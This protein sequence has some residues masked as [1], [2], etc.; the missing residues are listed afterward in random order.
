MTDAPH[1]RVAI[2]GAG[3]AGLYAAAHLIEQ[4][5]L[6]IEVDLLDALPTPWGL[7]RSA[8]APDHPEKKLI[9]D[10]YF[11][12]ILSHPQV[13]FFGNIRVGRDIGAEALSG[14]Y[15][16][17]IYAT[18]ADGDMKLGIDGETLRGVWS[19]REFVA[20]YN[21]HPDFASLPVDL[22]SDRAVIFGN[23]NVALDAAR[24]LTRDP[25]HLARTEIADH[26]LA[27]LRRSRVKEVVIVGRRG[28]F[29]SAYNCPE[30][31]E[32]AHIPEVDIVARGIDPSDLRHDEDLSDVARRKAR[33][34]CELAS[35]PSR[36]GNR[37]LI[38]QFHRAPLAFEGEDRVESVLLRD[39]RDVDGPPSRLTSGFVLRA[40]G[41]RGTPFPDL[42]FDETLGLIANRDGRVWNAKGPVT[43]VY[44]TGWIKRGCRGVIGTN[45]KCARQSV[46]HL[47]DD[48]TGGTLVPGRTNRDIALAAMTEAAPGIVQLD[49]WNRI[50]RAERI[51]GRP[52]GRPR[53]KLA[54]REALLGVAAGIATAPELELRH[55]G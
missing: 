20:W 48:F 23:G 33:I 51:A 9:I 46:A 49:G 12:F 25:A 28:H 30:L 6:H 42:P 31:E 50:D 39:T 43:G 41:Y 54:S 4:R 32:F 15:T 37:K 22:G 35:R 27:A 10:R 52:Q 45:K 17:V 55:E 2:V 24:I 1:M 40:I 14:L 44:V 13:R 18:G 47:L 36:A 8:V 29:E 7:V 38:F 21:G 5:D 19:A 34:L 53:I 3:P 11:Q 16:A 26:A